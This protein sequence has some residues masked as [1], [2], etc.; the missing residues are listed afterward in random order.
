MISSAR[1]QVTLLSPCTFPYL[2]ALEESS[3]V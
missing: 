2:N 3:D 1:H